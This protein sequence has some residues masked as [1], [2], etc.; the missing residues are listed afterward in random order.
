MTPREILYFSARLR[1][2]RSYR[3]RIKRVNKMIKQ[4]DLENCAD[5]MVGSTL[6]K[7]ISGGEKRR[8]SIGIELLTN[9]PVIFLDEP[10]SGLDSHTAKKIIQLL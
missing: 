7:G 2:K 5:T 9:P 10:T 8:T 6:E 4:L 1:L 3:G